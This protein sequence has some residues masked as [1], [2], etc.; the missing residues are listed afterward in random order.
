MTSLITARIDAEKRKKAEQ[1][2]D[3]LRMGCAEGKYKFAK[4]FDKRLDAMGSEIAEMF[5]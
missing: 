1:V 3:R 4:D 2:L 5:A